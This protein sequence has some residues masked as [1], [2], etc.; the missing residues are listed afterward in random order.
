[1]EI[2][3]GGYDPGKEKTERLVSTLSLLY[4]QKD[5]E[6]SGPYAK[7]RLRIMDAIENELKN[8]DVKDDPFHW[9]C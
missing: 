8:R 4:H 5:D 1:M 2:S 9:G 3:L 6:I 7:V